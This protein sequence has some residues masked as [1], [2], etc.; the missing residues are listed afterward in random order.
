MYPMLADK[1]SNMVCQKFLT[2]RL[3]VI[4]MVGR[5]VLGITEPTL[6]KRSPPHEKVYRMG[7]LKTLSPRS[8]RHI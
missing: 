6:D 8:P 7:R 2:Q 3:G 1:Y 4:F 5:A